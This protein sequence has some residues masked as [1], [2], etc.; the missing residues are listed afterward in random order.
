MYLKINTDIQCIN[1][2]IGQNYLAGLVNND[3]GVH[4]QNILQNDI[5]DSNI[6][7]NNQRQRDKNNFH[8][9]VINVMDFNKLKKE[10]SFSMYLLVNTLNEFNNFNVLGIGMAQKNDNIAYY[11]I[12]ENDDLNHIRQS[13]GLKKIDFHITLGFNYKDVHGISKGIKSKI[14]DI[15]KPL[16]FR[17][18]I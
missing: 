7:I 9:T 4:F 1:D 15:D 11:V 8:I 10:K 3:I 6:F 13:L 18:P 2:R 16:N 5:K 12:L 14:I 17:K